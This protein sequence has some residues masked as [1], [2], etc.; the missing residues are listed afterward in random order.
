MKFFGSL[1]RNTFLFEI[2]FDAD[3]K[4]ITGCDEK[5]KKPGATT[6]STAIIHLPCETTRHTSIKRSF[7]FVFKPFNK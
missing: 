5:D 6:D 3:D 1:I 2:I 7:Q 4:I